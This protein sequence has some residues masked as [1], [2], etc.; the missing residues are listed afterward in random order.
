MRICIVESPYTTPNRSR[1]EC[2]RYVCWACFDCIARGETPVA[3][4]LLYT[5]IL[6]E[7]DGARALGLKMRD[8]IAFATGGLIARYADIGET[9]GMH[10]DQDVTAQ[11]ETRKLEGPARQMWLD[12]KWPAASARLSVVDPFK[13][14]GGEQ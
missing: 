12:G 9:P 14:N 6:P 11:V 2:I 3:S 4:H 8:R 7:T 5:Q 10:R 13:Q 1:L